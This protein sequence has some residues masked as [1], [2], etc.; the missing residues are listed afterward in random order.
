MGCDIK[1]SPAGGL[2][3]STPLFKDGPIPGSSV[4]GIGHI[5]LVYLIL[6]LSVAESDR[7]GEDHDD[8]H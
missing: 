7:Q 4:K 1:P 5:P 3:V 2:E 8:H 6:G